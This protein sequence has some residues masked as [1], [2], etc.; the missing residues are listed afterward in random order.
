[1]N[2]IT[3]KFEFLWQKYIHPTQWDPVPYW[4]FEEY[5]KLMN[6]R[7]EDENKKKKEEDDEQKKSMSKYNFNPSQ[8]KFN[9]SQY[10]PKI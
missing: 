3:N 7:I 10:K 8:Y 5:I 2:L 6:K 4:E 9:P 1:M